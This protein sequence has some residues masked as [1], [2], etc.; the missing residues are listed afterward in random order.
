MALAL[1]ANRD[2]IST[3]VSENS[4]IHQSPFRQ[5]DR[6]Q[7]GDNTSGALCILSHPEPCQSE[8]E[9]LVVKLTALLLQ[10]G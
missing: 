7:E 8:R 6:T 10:G 5:Q 2:Y 1:W 9:F 3:P 4:N